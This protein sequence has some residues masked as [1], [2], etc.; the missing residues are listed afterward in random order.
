MSGQDPRPEDPAR[1]EESW[2]EP[3]GTGPGAAGPGGTGPGGTGSGWVDSPDLSATSPWGQSPPEPPGTQP[4][5]PLPPPAGPG[6]WPPAAGQPPTGY[7]RP[8]ATPYPGAP[9]PYPG[10]PYDYPPTGYPPTGYPPTGT[11]YPGG[12]PYPPAPQTS[13]DAVVA[14]V[15]AILSWVVC[16]ILPAIIALVY[17][18]RAQ[19]EIDASGGRLGGA[20]M[21]T[22]AKIVSWINIGLYAVVGVV[23]LVAVLIPLLLA[24][25]GG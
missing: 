10:T 7:G 9:A 15:L 22:A 21:V 25:T 24:S 23:M 8:G 19:R 18:G 16:P 1:P 2:G 12:Y 6:G 17:A 5:A 13:N 14:L 20:G 3:G 11:G 4:T